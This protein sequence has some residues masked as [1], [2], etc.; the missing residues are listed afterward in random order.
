MNRYILSFIIALAMLGISGCEDFLTP[1]PTD[2][3]WKRW[4]SAT[5]IMRSYTLTLSIPF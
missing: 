3:Y 2:K 1:E 5:K 4:L